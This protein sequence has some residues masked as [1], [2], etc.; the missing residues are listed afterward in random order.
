MYRDRHD[1]GRRLATE[2]EPYRH[3]SPVVVALPRGGVVVGYEVA[4]ALAAPLDILIVRKLGAPGHAELGIGAVVDLGGAC[5]VSGPEVLL[6]DLSRRLRIPGG[7]IEAEVDR[8]VEEAGR[9][10]R[11]YRGERPPMDLRQRVVILVDDGI[12][13]GS[14]T[15]AALRALRR[16]EPERLVL[17]VPVGPPETVGSMRREADDVVCPLTPDGFRAVGEFYENFS[18]TADEEVI[19]LL[20]QS[21][22]REGAS[23]RRA[24]G[25]PSGPPFGSP[26]CP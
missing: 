24:G 5:G 12:A 15:R 9:R 21:W 8:Q 1:A 2:V 16:C 13:T 6:D 18:Q 3:L 23:G 17:A 22:G 26:L 7:Y 10:E 14:S 11:V 25:L 19:G 4:E 20:D